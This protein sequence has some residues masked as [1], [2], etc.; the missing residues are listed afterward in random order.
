MSI[1]AE[2][3]L[4]FHLKHGISPAVIVSAMEDNGEDEGV[5]KD[6]IGLFEYEGYSEAN[7]R[8]AMRDLEI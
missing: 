7:I 5:V 3:Y 6:V 8:S 4:D 2:I 1:K